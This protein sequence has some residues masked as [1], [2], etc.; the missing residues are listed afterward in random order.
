MIV[1]TFDK[2]H[3]L[4]LSKTM[5]NNELAVKFNISTRTVSR[6]RNNIDSQFGQKTNSMTQ[7]LVKNK[8]LVIETV[9][10]Y[11]FKDASEK[12]GVSYTILKKFCFRNGIKRPKK[13]KPER[14]KRLKTVKQKTVTVKPE[15][16]I[17]L[18]PPKP[19]FEKS[20][21]PRAYNFGGIGTKN[22]TIKVKKPKIAKPKIYHLP[23]TGQCKFL[24]DNFALCANS[25]IQ[26]SP[27]CQEH[28]DLCYVEAV[29]LRVPK[30]AR[31]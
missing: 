31:L 25:H 14:Q 15:R 13:D 17:T 29:Q 9:S 30:E 28:H 16:I 21:Q 18:K 20:K 4:E 24:D 3:F 6:I 22:Q 27:Y 7:Q 1:D 2:K 26:G 10:N 11:N 19:K 8:E 23:Q 12:L 5:T